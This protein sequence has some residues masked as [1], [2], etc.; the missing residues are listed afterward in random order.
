VGTEQQAV[1]V[2]SISVL[3]LWD[4]LQIIPLKRNGYYMYHMFYR[5]HILPFAH[6]GYLLFRVVL[7]TNSGTAIISLNSINPLVVVMETKCF[8]EVRTECLNIN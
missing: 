1:Q 3:T 4:S 2:A 6:T 8:C 7:T 5:S